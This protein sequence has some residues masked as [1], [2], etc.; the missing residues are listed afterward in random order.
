[1]ADGDRPIGEL[2]SEAVQSL[3]RDGLVQLEADVVA[4]PAE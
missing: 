4:L 2:D 3:L 1:V